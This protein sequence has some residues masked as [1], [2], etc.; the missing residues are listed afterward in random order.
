MKILKILGICASIAVLSGCTRA[1]EPND[2]AYVVAIGVDKSGTE[3][4]YEFT[5]QIANP[6]AVSGG[7]SEQGGEGGEKTVSELTILAPSAFS[8]VN[9][10]NHLYSKQVSLAHTK[11]FV[12]R[13]EIAKNEGLKGHSETIARSEEIRPNTFMSVVKGSAKEYLSEIKPTNE[14]NPVQYYQVIYESDILSYIPENPCQDF[15]AYE[16]TDERENVLPLSGIQQ[17]GDS[18]PPLIYEGFEY[19]LKNYTAGEIQTDSEQKTQTIGMAIFSDG[20]MIAET[21]SVETEL[22]NI[23]TGTYNRSE[24]TYYDANS[25]EKP[26]TV[27]QFSQKKP[28]IKVDISGDH[29]VIYLKVFLEAD[30]RTV[31][32]NYL[33]EKEFD[34]FELEVQDEIKT[35]IDKFLYKTSREYKSDI[36]GFG[37][38]AKRKFRTYQD[39]HEYNWQEK[40]QNAE[41]VTEVEFRMRRSGL[42]D[43]KV[44]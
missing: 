3:N 29:P 16:L 17:E 27:A 44:G 14:V 20:K 41:F 4:N 38:Y 22:F 7:S 39:F 26:I 40:Y 21:G 15:Y 18:K 32:E 1:I 10:A 19:M 24:I 6:M 31:T 13:D 11:L 12:F 43:R 2:L 8:A 33:L 34:G 25:Q 23:I 28:I 5:L 36:V 30:L 9:M 37:S 35:A 42:I